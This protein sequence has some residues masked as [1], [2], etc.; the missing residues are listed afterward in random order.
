M[1]LTDDEK[2]W[3]AG[4]IEDKFKNHNLYMSKETREEFDIV[5]RNAAVHNE[6]WIRVDE[7]L[8]TIIDTMAG[9][10]TLYATKLELKNVESSI[11]NVKT[12]FSPTKAMVG[13]IITIIIT[14]VLTGGVALLLN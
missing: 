7:K 5:K 1:P 14:A 9:L 3:M 4:V 11:E 6:N 2:K 10:S 8:K 12:E 13:N